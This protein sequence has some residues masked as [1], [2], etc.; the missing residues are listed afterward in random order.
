MTPSKRPVTAAGSRDA[1]DRARSGNTTFTP[2]TPVPPG[3]WDPE[4]VESFR[5]RLLTF[6]R[7]RSRDL[8]WRESRDPYRILVSEF[9]LQQTRVETVIP[10]FRRWMDRFPSPATL[11][12][13]PQ[14]EVL[15]L[16]QGLGYY[17]RA[18]N[19][20]R[21]VRE[22]VD[23]YGGEVPDS[24]EGLRELP[25]VG[26]YTAGAVASIAY[27]VPA[28]AVDGNVRRV[29][30]RIMDAPAPTHREVE[31]W[32][33]PL[34]DPEAPADF[35]QGLMELG[36]LVCTP[37][38][39]RCGE[40]PVLPHCAARERGTEGERPRRKRRNPV[41]S[42][43]E[44][45]AVVVHGE[46]ILMERRPERGLLGGMWSLPGRELSGEESPGE[47]ALAAARSR[48]TGGWALLPTPERFDPL[49]AVEHLFS[50]RRVTYLPFRIP[51]PDGSAPEPT[52]DARWVTRLEALEELPLPAAQRKILTALP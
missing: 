22:V 1:A 37:R 10:Y 44:G 39:P 29:M 28:P 17:S 41:P 5:S 20:H 36:S 11:A 13:A 21:A 32:V 26:A 52:G 19:L 27:G 2:H 48:L 15:T 3:E 23:R 24:V 16:W 35:N 40:C 34:V 7:S 31:E 25:G 49:P 8:P 46:R 4:R 9:M 50:H 12:D 33:A 47:G 14:E 45:V 42:F 6:F 18:R 51:L 43:Q 38:N 30:A